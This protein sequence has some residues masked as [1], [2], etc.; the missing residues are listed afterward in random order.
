M[1]AR[2]SFSNPAKRKSSKAISALAVFSLLSSIL[3]SINPLASN[4]CWLPISFGP[5]TTISVGDSPYALALEDLNND[6]NL[7]L[8]TANRAS[9]DISI[10]LGTGTGTFSIAGGNTYPMGGAPNDVVLRDFN[11]DGKFDVATADSTGD[12]VSWRIGNGDGTF[13]N[14]TTCA[15]TS[16]PESLVPGD[17]DGDG[18]T[19]LAVACSTTGRIYLVWGDGTGAFSTSTWLTGAGTP[20]ALDAGD[21]N[22]DGRTDIV[23]A[24][25]PG[26]RVAIFRNIGG[27]AFDTATYTAVGYKPESITL[28][29]I[30]HDEK[31]DLVTG[32]TSDTSVRLGKGD[33]TKGEGG[34]YT[35]ATYTAGP[36]ADAVALGDLNNDSLIDLVAANYGAFNIGIRPGNGSGGFGSETTLA[37]PGYLTD[38]ALGDLNNDGRND[39]VSTTNDSSNNVHIFLNLGKY[40]YD[41][42]WYDCK[43]MKTWILLGNPSETESVYVDVYIAGVHKLG[44]TLAAGESYYAIFPD[45]IGGPVTIFANKPIYTTLRSLYVDSFCEVPGAYGGTLDTKH[46]FPWY[47]CKYMKTWILVSNPN[48]YNSATFTIYLGGAPKETQT[49]GAGESY[50]AYYDG[51]MGGPVKI[52]SDKPV[53]ASE[54]SLYGGSFSEV[55]GITEADLATAYFFPW[56]DC[57]YMKTWILVSNPSETSS[58]AFG[59]TIAGE[60]K[61]LG[62]LA[63]GESYYAIYPGVIGGPV[64]INATIPVYA[65]QRSLYPYE[66]PTSFNEIPG[67]A[68]PDALSQM[69]YFPWYDCQYMKTWILVSNASPTDPATVDIYIGGT[70]KETKV[71]NPG[72]SYYAMYPGVMGGPVKIVSSIPIFAT[73]RSLYPYASPTS[74]WEVTGLTVP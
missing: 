4:A 74:F 22:K 42:P 44:K 20:M 25:K 15:V 19:D 63:P 21:L 40:S 36:Y 73:Q 64:T 67:I 46:Y 71:L 57:Q 18:N 12:T 3:L 11:K 54:R 58:A 6:G 61:H 35:E 7:D 66:S 28:G 27:G 10:R 43:Y 33:L 65:T 17:F 47:D 56:Y 59:I 9:N 53:A 72:Q 48:E 39:V 68:F 26:N 50:Y 55:Y 2:L 32:N 29:D 51:V 62:S 30:N 24:D 60:T 70:K 23:A 16:G 41:F 38:V 49:L 69:F 52:L 14:V 5:R 31:L 8:V 13:G 1:N 45:V 34:F 37:V